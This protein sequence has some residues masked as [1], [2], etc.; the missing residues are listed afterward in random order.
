MKI[1]AARR[2]TVSHFC[3]RA[4]SGHLCVSAFASCRHTEGAALPSL[5][6]VCR[7]HRLTLRQFDA[8]HATVYALFRALQQVSNIQ[9]DLI[10]ED[11]LTAKRLSTLKAL[12]ITEPD[13]PIE[14][15]TAVAQW[16]KAGGSLLTVTGAASGDRYNQ[17]TTVL[18]SATGIVE[19]PR[20][21]KMIQ[22][23]SKLPAADTGSGEL[24]AFTAY[25]VRGNVTA[26][27][28][29]GFK[30][31]AA[32]SDGSPAIVQNTAVGRGMATHFAFLPGIRFRNQNPYRADPH[33]VRRM[34]LWLSG[35]ARCCLA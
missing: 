35:V 7:L 2:W 4:A 8:D 22:W 14:G 20:P 12:I 23:T 5:C 24:G 17:P 15:Q 28:S 21:R 33:Y 31:L 27:P 25:G 13:V 19:A 32:F 9:V 10:D 11:D 18:S 1:K 34:R 6:L 16:V 30:Q 3:P 29:T 26:S